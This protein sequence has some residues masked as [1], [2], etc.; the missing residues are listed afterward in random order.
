M[1]GL[2]FVLMGIGLASLVAAVQAWRVGEAF[3]DVRLLAGVSA[4]F[5][6]PGLVIALDLLG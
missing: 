1:A 4:T 3:R 2:G 6:S 5:A